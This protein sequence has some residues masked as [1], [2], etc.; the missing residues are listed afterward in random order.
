MNLPKSIRIGFRDF[1]VIGVDNMDPERFGECDVNRSIIRIANGYDNL[2]TA[3]TVLHEVLHGAWSAARLADKES[4][5]KAVTHLA[6]VM[7]QV[8]RDNPDLV[9]YLCWATSEVRA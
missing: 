5:E 1:A 8:W 6:D 2:R 4:E 9:T 7:T 3:N